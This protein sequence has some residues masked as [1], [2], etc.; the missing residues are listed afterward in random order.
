MATPIGRLRERVE[1]YSPVRG[2]E[3]SGDSMLTFALAATVWG[4]VVPV[5]GREDQKDDRPQAAITHRVTIRQRYDVKA[6]W[7]LRVMPATVPGRPEQW[8][9]IVAIGKAPLRDYLWIDAAE[10]AAPTE[11]AE[12]LTWGQ[13]AFT[14]GGA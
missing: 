8:L 4:E 7:M 2:Q 11:V 9:Q 6:D 14:F 3:A 12:G 13:A 5:A 10:R 1:L